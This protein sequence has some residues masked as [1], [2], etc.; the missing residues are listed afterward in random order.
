MGGGGGGE[1]IMRTFIG[2]IVSD[3]MH[4]GVVVAVERMFKHP[5]Y[6]RT[7]RR[8][9]KLMAHD[10]ENKCTLGDTVRIEATRPIS[11]RKRYV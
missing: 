2:K 5:K 1:G 8:T 4:K 9:T 6:A 11:R 3:K 10:E 7:V